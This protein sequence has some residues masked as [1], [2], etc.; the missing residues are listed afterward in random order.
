MKVSTIAL[1]ISSILLLSAC[2]GGSSDSDKTSSTRSIQGKAIDGYVKGATVGLDLNFNGKLDAGEPTTITGDNGTY[3]LDIKSNQDASCADYV[4]TIVNVP[5]GAIDEDLGI[6]ETAYTMTL[7]PAIFIPSDKDIRDITPLTTVLWENIQQDLESNNLGMLSC[8]TIQHQSETRERISTMLREQEFRLQRRFNVP[9]EE[10]YSDFIA[11]GNAKLA[12]SAANL[13][14]GMQLSYEE[15]RVLY[16]DPNV[17]YAEVEYMQGHWNYMMENESNSKFWHRVTTIQYKDRSTTTRIERMSDDLT[18]VVNIFEDSMKR[19]RNER[20]LS[21]IERYAVEPDGCNISVELVQA[22]ADGHGLRNHHYI[23]NINSLSA[24]QNAAEE[25]NLTMQTILAYR[26]NGIDD[27][28]KIE[29]LGQFEYDSSQVFSYRDLV[30]AFDSMSV[31]ELNQ[32]NYIS[33]DFNDNSIHS[34]K[35]VLRQH[36][37]NLDDRYI[38]L[39]RNV[40]RGTWSKQIQYKSGLYE[41]YCSQDGETWTPAN[42][43]SDCDK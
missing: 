32:F 17:V 12:V 29:E 25:N 36:S 20:G 14:K 21:L 35:S 4:P 23:S 3:I 31:D 30:T 40:I 28:G 41:F 27:I 6:V 34:S 43:I 33:A 7:A 16:Q 11:S 18:N 10:L 13:V 1:G 26:S 22:K 37:T 9:V 39:S 38:W 5:I 8:S 15:T 19:E 42:K 24:C 2:G